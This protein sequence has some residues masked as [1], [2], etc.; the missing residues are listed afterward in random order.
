MDIKG[1]SSESSEGNERTFFFFLILEE[2]GSL[3][4]GGRKLSRSV[5]CSY[6]EN[7]TGT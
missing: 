6:V 3:S 2:R 5:S 4:F 1:S 7:T